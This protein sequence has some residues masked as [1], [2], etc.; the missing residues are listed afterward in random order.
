ML[1]F[2]TR[3]ISIRHFRRSFAQANRKSESVEKDWWKENDK[4]KENRSKDQLNLV[5][6]E[7]DNCN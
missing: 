4:L 2:H 5:F 3:G 6:V 7:G 1:C